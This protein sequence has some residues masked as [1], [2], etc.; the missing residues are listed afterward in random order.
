MFKL[1][2]PE[3]SG[4]DGFDLGIEILLPE[5]ASPNSAGERL[6]QG[7]HIVGHNNYTP[8]RSVLKADPQVL[9]QRAGTGTPVGSVPRG[10]AGFKERI[11]FGETIGDFVKDGVPT[12]TSN[13]IIT[14]AGD[15]SIHI[16]PAAP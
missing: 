15:G 4:L 12:P 6:Q 14:Y 5:I 1:R 11:N 8:G 7:K 3:I 2:Y 10:E 13:G 16:I 9:A